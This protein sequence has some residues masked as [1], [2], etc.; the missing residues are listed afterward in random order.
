MNPLSD[1]TSS[2][3]L[4]VKTDAVS[5]LRERRIAHCLIGIVVTII[6]L[7]GYLTTWSARWQD[8][9]VASKTADSAGY[10]SWGYAVLNEGT[11]DPGPTLQRW[12]PDEFPVREVNGRPVNLNKFP[13]GW[14]LATF[15][16]MA[17][18]KGVAILRGW[19]SADPRTLDAMIRGAHFGVLF[20]A[21]TG[22]L[23]AYGALSLFT[24]ALPAALST[25]FIW[26]GTSA[27]AYTW[28]RHLHVTRGSRW[29]LS[30]SLFSRRSAR[31]KAIFRFAGP[32]FFGLSFGMV[33]CCRIV[34]IM[35]VLPAPALLCMRVEAIS[36]GPSIQNLAW[37]NRPRIARMATV[38]RALRESG[39]AASD[40]G[41]DLENGLR[42]MGSPRI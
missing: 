13:I 25:F 4:F 35:L 28:A 30:A 34:N 33:V 27:F 21:A 16:F 22:M 3:A 37:R 26:L 20:W 9:P 10:F 1:S 17:A 42:I 5:E 39:L 23:C 6:V 18:A 2:S 7:G 36:V 24:T 38:R 40:T 31:L 19:S 14:S 8:G 12:S 32:S 15:P 29:P 41:V 11:F